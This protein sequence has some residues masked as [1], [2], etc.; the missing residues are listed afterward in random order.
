M[1]DSALPQVM[2]LDGDSPFTSFLALTG[3]ASA[4]NFIVTADSVPVLYTTFAQNFAD[5]T[6]SP[7]LSVAMI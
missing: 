6:G 1:V 4:L 7:L 5:V 2:S 3:I